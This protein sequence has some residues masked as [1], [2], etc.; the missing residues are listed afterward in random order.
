LNT[1]G[2]NDSQRFFDDFGLQ[3]VRA[4]R[5]WDFSDPQAE[6]GTD[7]VDRAIYG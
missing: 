2:S 3:L 7:W 5:K 1:L 4:R 6:Q